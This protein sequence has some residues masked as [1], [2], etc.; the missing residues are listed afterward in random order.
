M[1]RLPRQQESPPEL[2]WPAAKAEALR[3]WGDEVERI[4][5]EDERARDVYT[6]LLQGRPDEA[7]QIVEEIREDAIDAVVRKHPH[8]FA[9]YQL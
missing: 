5:G 6:A 7:L 2:D 1:E 3:G 9:E 8:E 4:M